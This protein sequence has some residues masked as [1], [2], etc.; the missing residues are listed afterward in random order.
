[1]SDATFITGFPGFIAGRLVE[2]LADPSRRIILLVERRFADKARRDAAEI[3]QRLG[4]SSDAFEIVE[5]DITAPNLGLSIPTLER[6]K[7]SVTEVFHL[8]AIYDLAVSKDL[9]F[10]VNVDGTRNV[11][12]FVKALKRL[13]RYNYVSTCYVAGRRLG[14]ILETELR[15]EAGFRNHYEE[16]KYLAEL[17]VEAL[18]GEVPLTIFRPSVVVG[19]SKTGETPKYDGIYYLIKYLLK[20]PSLLRF[21]NVGNSEVTLNLVPVDFIV[22]GIVALARR[23]DALGKTVALADPSPMTTA[24]LFDAIAEALTGRRSIL[25]PP[26]ALVKIFLNLP[27][28]PPLTGLPKHGVPYFFL[29]QRY[30]TSIGTELLAASGVKCPRFNE[31]VAELVGFVKR[32]PNP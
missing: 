22:D 11:N 25:I 12:A 8:A 10:K 13:S 9:A 3:A 4:L 5:G 30:D 32:N 27:I 31:Y 19:D 6:M 15:H 21:V 17:E 24:E 16:T 14:K 23:E 20:A 29:S 28:S 7:D 1:M 26:T 18:K 2:R